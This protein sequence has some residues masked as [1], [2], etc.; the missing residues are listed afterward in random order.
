MV[1]LGNKTQIL[2]TKKNSKGH[3]NTLENDRT[4][5]TNAERINLKKEVLIM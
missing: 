1:W 2:K 5:D 3:Q 4:R